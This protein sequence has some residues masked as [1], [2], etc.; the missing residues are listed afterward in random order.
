MLYE[1]LRPNPA[2]PLKIRLGTAFAWDFDGAAIRVAQLWGEGIVQTRVFGGAVVGAAMLLL[3]TGAASAAPFTGDVDVWNV[4]TGQQNGNFVG[5]EEDL[6]GLNLQLALRATNRQGAYITPVGDTYTV[7]AGSQPGV[8]TRARWNFDIHV[9]FEGVIASDL[10][11][12]YLEVEK[13]P[14]GVDGYEMFN[15]LDTTLRAAIDCH[16]I[17]PACASSTPPSGSSSSGP[18]T[19][20]PVNFYQAS[21]NP[22]FAP[23]FT[24]IGFDTT[25]VATYTLRLGGMTG[26]G[27]FDT[28]IVVDVVAAPTPAPEPA[29]LSLRGLGLLGLAA[30]R[31]RKA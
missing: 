27:G 29:A 22:V 18:H 28:Q 8:P 14:G 4:G 7:L 30:A 6:G 23:W 21:Q 12:L 16:T 31:R 17:A 13:G 25:G 10:T 19:G 2:N 26:E 15:L 11:A 3:M 1:P 24:N 5:R 9:S 20:N